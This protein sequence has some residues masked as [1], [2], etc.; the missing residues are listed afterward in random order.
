MKAIIQFFKVGNQYGY[1][2]NVAGMVDTETEYQ[3]DFKQMLAS[4]KE[5]ARRMGAKEYRLDMHQSLPSDAGYS[6]IMA[7]AGE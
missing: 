7:D 1:S 5:T 4:A 6:I 2:V 3:P